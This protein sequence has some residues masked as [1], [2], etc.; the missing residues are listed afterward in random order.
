MIA[1]YSA[2]HPDFDGDPPHFES[3]FTAVP[4][5][6]NNSGTVH[7]PTLIALLL[8]LILKLIL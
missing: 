7:H 2:E 8:Y 4:A 6:T 5:I 3:A 1:T